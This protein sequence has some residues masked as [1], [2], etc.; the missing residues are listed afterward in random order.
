MD[1]DELLGAAF[2]GIVR[3]N[4]DRLYRVAYTYVRSEE[5][6]E[7]VVQGALLKVWHRRSGLDLADPLPCLFRAVL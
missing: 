3:A 2:E 1:G 4:Y 6:A 7:D 5:D